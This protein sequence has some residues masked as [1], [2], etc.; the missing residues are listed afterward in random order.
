MYV[1]WAEMYQLLSWVSPRTVRTR[2]PAQFLVHF[3]D[4]TP[5]I[6][7]EKRIFA[8]ATGSSEL[9]PKNPKVV[10][11]GKRKASHESRSASTI[12]VN[13]SSGPGFPAL[14][15]DELRSQVQRIVMYGAIRETM[16]SANDRAYRNVSQDDILAM[17]EGNW[18]L[19]GAPDWDSGHRN[20]EYKIAG[21]DIEGDPLV[22]KIAV[23][24]EMQRIDIITKY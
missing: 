10:E 2:F 3:H 20:W 9:N 8:D 1:P 18:V 15:P 4:S 17:L 19:R 5:R 14:D 13:A 22:L 23:N 21:A 7:G 12:D 24:V 6:E 11:I 16:H